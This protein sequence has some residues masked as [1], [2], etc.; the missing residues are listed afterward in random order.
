MYFNQPYVPQLICHTKYQRIFHFISAEVDVVYAKIKP[1]TSSSDGDDNVLQKAADKIVEKFVASGLMR[2]QYDRVKLHVTVM[3]TKFKRTFQEQNEKS[4]Q[5]SASDE[6]NLKKDAGSTT[7]EK[8][9][10]REILN[11]FGDR[12]FST[13]HINEM[14]L[15]QLKTGRRARTGK[16][17]SDEN[18][19]AASTIVQLSSCG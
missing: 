7:R 11:R 17:I 9:D 16:S 2:R 12:H 8:I 13:T 19:Y 3:N 5:N 6:N 1:A 18:Y 14:H 4:T 15:S 10:A